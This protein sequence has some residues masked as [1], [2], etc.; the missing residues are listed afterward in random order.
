MMNVVKLIL[1]Q[2]LRSEET[3]ETV[4]QLFKR[5]REREREKEREVHGQTIYFFLTFAVFSAL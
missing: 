4:I 5:E 3:C 1:K 2:L